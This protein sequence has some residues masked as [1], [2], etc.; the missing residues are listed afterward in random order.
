MNKSFK[1]C[2]IIYSMDELAETVSGYGDGK[3][4]KQSFLNLIA[5]FLR[6]INVLRSNPGLFP[7]FPPLF[8]HKKFS[9]LQSLDFVN[10]PLT[11]TPKIN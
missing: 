8:R 5:F 7:I 4:Q 11:F 3:K 10:L 1:C 9:A 6:V 2:G